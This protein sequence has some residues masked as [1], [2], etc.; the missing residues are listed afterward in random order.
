MTVI[1]PDE[2]GAFEKFADDFPFL[3][4][5]VADIKR[6]KPNEFYS[7]LDESGRAYVVIKAKNAR[8]T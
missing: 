7:A 6:M 1:A 8:R 5:H 4:K 3:K 2:Q